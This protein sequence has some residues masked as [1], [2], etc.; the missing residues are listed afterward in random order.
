MHSVFQ[1]SQRM[2][3]A[4]VL[5]AVHLGCFATEDSAAHMYDRAAVCV[6]GPQ[7]ILNFPRKCYDYDGL[8]NGWVS[9]KQQLLSILCM[10]VASLYACCCAI[11]YV[12]SSVHDQTCQVL[13]A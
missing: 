2:F 5:Q 1:V 4:A 6:R 3:T 13:Q 12:S 7:A 11:Y 10:H 8:P 9:S